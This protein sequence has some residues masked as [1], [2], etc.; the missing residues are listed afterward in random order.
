MSNKQRLKKKQKLSPEE[1]LDA[2]VRRLIGQLHT[3]TAQLT[4]HPAQD[5]LLVDVRTYTE[6][7]LV[8]L[9]APVERSN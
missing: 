3:V 9:L 7:Y 8:P 6:H 1:R 2:T 5:Q 4:A